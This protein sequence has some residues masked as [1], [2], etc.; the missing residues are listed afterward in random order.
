LHCLKEREVHG[1][2]PLTPYLYIVHGVE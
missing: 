1:I 2:N